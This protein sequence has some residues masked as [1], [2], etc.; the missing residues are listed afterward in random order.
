MLFVLSASVVICAYG[1]LPDAIAMQPAQ[2]IAN[3][4]GSTINIR[5]APSTQADAWYFGRVGDRAQI[6]E[7]TWGRD[8]FTWYRVN[9]AQTGVTGWVRADFVRPLASVP[10]PKQNPAPIARSPQIDS[11]SSNI[12]LPPQPVSAPAPLDLETSNCTPTYPI[13]NPQINF[14]FGQSPDPFNPGQ[15]R[16]HNGI[17]FAGV[18]G[19]A[20]YSPICGTV[21]YAGRE[22]DPTSYEWGYGWHVKIQDS[23]GRLHLFGHVSK[24]YVRQGARVIPGT[25][26]ADVGN[27]GNS[28]GPH[29]HYEIR[30]GGD[31]YKAAINPKP[32][33]AQARPVQQAGLIPVQS[34]E[35]SPRTGGT[36]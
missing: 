25:R 14:D 26:I 34:A 11:S 21:T 10:Q 35:P 22:Q 17:D 6:L 23:Q 12:P 1:K 3:D 2:L 27:N 30:Q 5:Q 31:T 7:Q 4:P 18:I 36:L 8:G 16:W 20:I 9:M 29:L 24:M 19:D 15:M 33:L 13:A 32:F 28:T